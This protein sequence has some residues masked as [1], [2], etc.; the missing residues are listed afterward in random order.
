MKEIDEYLYRHEIETHKKR[1]AIAKALKEGR[2]YKEIEKELNTSSATVSAVKR[3]ME[4]R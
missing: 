1:Q 4:G 2:T 3:M